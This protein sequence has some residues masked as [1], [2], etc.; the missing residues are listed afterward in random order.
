M[1]VP[2]VSDLHPNLE[3]IGAQPSDFDRL[4]VLGDL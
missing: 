4:W 1:R 2:I 3:A